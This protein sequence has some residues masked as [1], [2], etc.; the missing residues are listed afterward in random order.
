MPGGH[1]GGAVRARE[2]ALEGLPGVE[3]SSKLVG[4]RSLNAL[5]RPV[6]VPNGDMT[7]KS[8]P[9]LKI[10]L[11]I[12]HRRLFPVDYS[13]AGIFE[14]FESRECSKTDPSELSLQLPVEIA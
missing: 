1:G 11:G 14:L 7:I 8:R 13:S 6:E 12:A 10:E 4:K 3:S 9:M 5:L 2:L